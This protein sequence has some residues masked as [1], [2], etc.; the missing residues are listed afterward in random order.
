[1]SMNQRGPQACTAVRRSLLKS[2]Q[3]NHGIIAVNLRKV[4]VGKVGDQ[5][6]DASSR[7]VYFD[8]DA[9]GIPVVFDA[10]NDR[11]LLVRR[12]VDRLPEF[13]LRG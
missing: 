4:E 8:G 1:M 11:Q 13:A 5:P 9:D 7:R 6:R 10:E 2:A 12:S 3:A